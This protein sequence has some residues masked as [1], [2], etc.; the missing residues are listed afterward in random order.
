MRPKLTTALQA[1]AITTCLL[2]WLYFARIYGDYSR[3]LQR[4]PL[5]IFDECSTSNPQH[6]AEESILEAETVWQTEKV[7]W[8]QIEA[9]GPLDKKHNNVISDF[10]ME[11]RS[12]DGI[13]GR[14]HMPA[15]RLSFTLN[16]TL[17]ILFQLI[18]SSGG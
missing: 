14:H 11:L 13:H 5:R 18:C 7:D 17:D 16:S 4:P 6:C 9:I 15:L 2:V 3:S 8:A 10:A 12:S 1:V